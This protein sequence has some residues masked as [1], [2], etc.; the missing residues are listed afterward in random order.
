LVRAWSAREAFFACS[1]RSVA[2]S[3]T[4]SYRCP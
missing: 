1:R 2:P 3:L 4:P